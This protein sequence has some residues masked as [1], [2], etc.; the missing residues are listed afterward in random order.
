MIDMG[1]WRISKDEILAIARR[2]GRF[3]VPRY[4]W[5]AESMARKCREMCRD[6]LLKRSRRLSSRDEVVYIPQKFVDNSFDDL[7]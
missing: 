1:P 2:K 5:R 7:I 6:G 4:L 3:A